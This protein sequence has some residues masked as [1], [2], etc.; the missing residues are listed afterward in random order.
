MPRFRRLLSDPFRQALV[1]NPFWKNIRADRSLQPEIR[2]DCVTVYYH[3]RALVR[4]IRMYEGRI[5]AKVHRKF[6]PLR[7]EASDQ[8]LSA[9]WTQDRGFVFDA[10]LEPQQL[11]NAEAN[12]IA[13]YKRMILHE[14][15]PEDRLVQGIIMNRENRIVD[16]QV[17][18][19]IRETNRIDLYHF[20]RSIEKLVAVEVKRVDDLRLFEPVDEPAV[21]SQLR[22]Y[23]NWISSGRDC[24]EAAYANVIR[25]K[26]QLHLGERLEGVPDE[27]RAA[28]KPVLVIGNC[29]NEDVQ[30]FRAAWQN[31]VRNRWSPLI[32]GLSAVCLGVVMCGFQGCS[33]SI[34]EPSA[35][36]FPCEPRQ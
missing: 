28:A 30:Q 20:D 2:H 22:A 6:I 8:Y 36:K 29:R 15:G 13:A 5:I 27:C 21:I 32:A 11:A 33:L 35:Q 16:Q 12:A 23:G 1:D 10:K 14:A 19:P 9:A 7:H 31:E 17:Q 24:L 3:G 26:R 25:W 34:M 18:F 4:E